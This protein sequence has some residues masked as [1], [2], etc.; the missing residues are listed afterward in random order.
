MKRPVFSFRPNMKNPDH[1]T[2]WKVLESIPE[3]QK[4]GFMVQALLH[5][6]EAGY[7]EEL[8]R[9][10]IREELG[11]ISISMDGKCVPEEAVPEAF[12]DFIS[13][14]QEE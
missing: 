11:S 10:I 9:K 14:L 12:L 7:L 8:I 1:E 6:K 5:E 13:M 3:G 4:T 2:A